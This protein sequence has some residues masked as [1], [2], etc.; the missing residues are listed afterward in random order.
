MPQRF[1]LD[2]RCGWAYLGLWLLGCTGAPPALLP[3]GLGTVEAG[4]VAGWVSATLPPAS[5]RHRFRWL[6]EDEKSSKGGRGSA[7]V[8]PP[9]TLRFDFAGSL[10]LGKGAALV[11]GDSARW[12]V[13]ERSVEELVP[14]LPLLWALFGVA[15]PPEAGATLAGLVQEGRT[16]WRYAAGADTVDYLRVSGE[17]ITLHA[18]MRQAGKVVG[19]SRMTRKPDGT[20]LTA[21]LSV[22]SVPA[23]LEITFYETVPSPGFPPAT[24]RA[25][26]E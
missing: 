10:G 17:V 18:E 9:D 20:P 8:A 7:H 23:K 19:R 1:R 15:R 11:V 6:Y 25:P 14:S 5:A 16:A 2:P 21:F 22:P 13:P 3:S 12:V 4:E 24:W 26:A